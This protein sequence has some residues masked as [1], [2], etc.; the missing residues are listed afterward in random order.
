MLRGEEQPRREAAAIAVE[1][2][3]ESPR[4]SE[5]SRTCLS[6]P[7]AEWSGDSEWL[8]KG[9][10]ITLGGGLAGRALSVA[11]QIVLARLLG[12]AAYGF[13]AIGWAL[14]RVANL[15]APL[16]LNSGVIHC[17]TRYAT[18]DP[19]QLR[20]VVRNSLAL[21]I[22]SGA[23]L[24]LAICVAAPVLASRVFGK[25]DL[26][27]VIYLFA[28]GVPLGAG[29]QVACAATKVSQSMKYS[30]YAE[31]I[32][33][34]AA[35]LVLIAV[36]Y[37]IGWK[38]MGAVAAAV[39][40]FGAGLALALF[41]E[42]QL[43]DR[44]PSVAAS[45][46]APVTRELLQFS[47]VAWL[48]TIFVNTMPW[49]DRLFVGSYLAPAA[50]GTY[51]VAAQTA[52][53]LSIV[54]AAFNQVI[55]PRISLLHHEA[56]TERMQ[57]VYKV[58]TKWGLYATLPIVAVF[59]AAPRQVLEGLYGKAYAGGATVLVLLSI[60]RLIDAAAGPVGNFSIFTD[61]RRLFSAVSGC[62]LF[63]CIA[64][65]YF[66]IPHLGAV[67]AALATGLSGMA[68][69]LAMLVPVK[70]KLGIWPFDA[71]WTKGLLAAGAAFVAI[72]AGKFIDIRPAALKLLALL[73]LDMA[74]FVGALLSLGLDTEDR[75]LVRTIRAYVVT[76]VH[77]YGAGG[78]SRGRI[79]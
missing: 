15:V 3:E 59:C 48:G 1:I 46:A 19:G 7:A 23:L 30:V 11:G 56:Q 57:Q 47:V 61:R 68:V 72:L 51:Q 73:A 39:F 62:G 37:F 28:A 50:V 17:A 78:A 77:P 25:G 9:S 6:S 71:R 8:A 42:R 75:R 12:P 44:V 52:V 13:Y 14:L 60:M 36:F 4:A 18:F 63:L 10:A 49:V 74:V 70:V 33:Q 32:M 38:L 65:N 29:L 35:N 69:M 21:A 76:R 64:L 31:L 53:L 26:L 45:Q 20:R 41:H 16:G 27:P 22:L 40:S 55:A 66:F 67:G 58:A 5:R 54:A 43:L 2:H 34:P 79:G 24:G